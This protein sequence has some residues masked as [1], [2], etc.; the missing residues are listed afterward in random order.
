MKVCN[1]DHR[2]FVE[3]PRLLGSYWAAALVS[4]ENDALFS[5]VTQAYSEKGNP[6]SPNRSRTYDNPI[7]SSD[8]AT[9]ELQ[10]TRGS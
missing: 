7:T 6:S 1:C 3:C 8:V 5:L 10:E 9:T 2:A 4:I